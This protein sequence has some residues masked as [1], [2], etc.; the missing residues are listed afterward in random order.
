MR[1]VE[2]PFP[3]VN[4]RADAVLL[5]CISS[6]PREACDSWAGACAQDGMSREQDTTRSGAITRVI[7]RESNAFLEH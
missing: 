1:P 5:A 2:R 6:V 7:V 4:A 3:G